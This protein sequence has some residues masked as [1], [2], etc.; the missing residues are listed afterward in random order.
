MNIF[1]NISAESELRDLIT[2][3]AEEQAEASIWFEDRREECIAS[4]EEN[5]KNI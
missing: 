1:E 5:E 2:L 4:M 3:S